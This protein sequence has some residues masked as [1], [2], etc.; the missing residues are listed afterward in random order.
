M[1]APPS[2]AGCGMVEFSLMV[3][4]DEE[5]SRPHSEGKGMKFDSVFAG[6]HYFLSATSLGEGPWQGEANVRVKA[7]SA[8]RSKQIPTTQNLRTSADAMR[9]A[10]EQLKALCLS[11]VLRVAVPAAYEELAGPQPELISGSR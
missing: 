11:G 4:Y 1:H 7:G 9:G 8:Y 5:P 3:R 6:V 2:V 10:E